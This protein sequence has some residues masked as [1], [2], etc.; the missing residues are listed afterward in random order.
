MLIGRQIREARSLLRLSVRDFATRSVL[1]EAVVVR[2][3]TVDGMATIT[4]AQSAAI[5]C[6]V[7]REDLIFTLASI[8]RPKQQHE[9]QE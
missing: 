4:L 1:D 8:S 6:A 5:R 9:G 7:E 3:E 2:A